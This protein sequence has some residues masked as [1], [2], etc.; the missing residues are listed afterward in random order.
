MAGSTDRNDP[1]AY[2][3]SHFREIARRNRFAE[4]ATIEHDVSR[5]AVCNPG[6]AGREPFAVY[7]EVVA[8]S[9]LERRPK[10]DDGLVAEINSDRE[11]EGLD[12]ITMASLAAGDPDAVKSWAAWV[13]EALATGLGLLS[14]HSPTSME[15]DP[16]EQEE[17]GHG[18]LIESAIR[19]VMER[20]RKAAG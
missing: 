15:F 20:Q 18:P 11:A 16:D 13:R 1:I 17:A 14:V 5:C 10:L 19:Y 9:V 7:L 3:V 6:M 4:N 8:E 2:T 12:R